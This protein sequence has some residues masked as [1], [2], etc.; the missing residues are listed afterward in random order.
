MRF[1]D[2][3]DRQVIV[4]ATGSGKTHAALWHLSRRDYDTKPWIIYDFKYDDLIGEMPNVHHTDLKHVPERPGIYVVHPH[5]GAGDAVTDHMWRIWEQGNTGVYVDEGYM[6]ESGNKAFRSLLTQGRSKHIPMIVLSQRPVWIDRFTMTE[7][8]YH[9]IFRLQHN[10]DYKVVM[11]VVPF[12]SQPWF[13]RGGYRVPPRLP[14]HHSYY[15]DVGEDELQH[16]GPV[17]DRD[18]IMDTFARRLERLK[19]VV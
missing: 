14:R 3:T 1:P 5:P 9:Q 13:K 19:K 17:P 2:D 10:D 7:A 18:A 8:G 6:I 12:Q 15:Y 4:G 16:L 11:G